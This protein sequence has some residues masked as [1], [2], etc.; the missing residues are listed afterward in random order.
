MKIKKRKLKRMK[1]PKNSK[2]TEK[3]NVLISGVKV[4][5]IKYFEGKIHFKQIYKYWLDL[6]DLEKIKFMIENK[7]E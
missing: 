4:G 3:N 7:N 2:I 5:T 6:K 1:L